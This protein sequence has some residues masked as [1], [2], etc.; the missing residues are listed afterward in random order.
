MYKFIQTKSD[1]TFCFQSKEGELSVALEG[2]KDL[3]TGFS[4]HFLTSLFISGLF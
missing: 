3:F 4:F 2:E 1:S